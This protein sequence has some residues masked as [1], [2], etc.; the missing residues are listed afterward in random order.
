MYATKIVEI[1][2]VVLVCCVCGD[3]SWLKEEQTDETT[4][5]VTA[6]RD[7]LPGINRAMFWNCLVIPFSNAA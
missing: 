7:Q 1:M 2:A 4:A 6:Q 5:E 3:Y